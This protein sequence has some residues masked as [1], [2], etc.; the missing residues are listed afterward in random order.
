MPAAGEYRCGLNKSIKQQ[1]EE[2][3]TIWK[4][5]HQGSGTTKWTLVGLWITED[6]AKTAL[7]CYMVNKVSGTAHIMSFI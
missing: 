5:K 3:G 6:Y 7:G 4:V 2:T 1:G